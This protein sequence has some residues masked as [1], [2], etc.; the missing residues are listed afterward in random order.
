VSVNDVDIKGFNADRSRA[1]KEER[2]RQTG[3]A[4]SS[5]KFSGEMENFL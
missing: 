1:K 4:V 3:L 2:R 5:I